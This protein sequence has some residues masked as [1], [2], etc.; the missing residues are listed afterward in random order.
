MILFGIYLFAN[1]F[2]GGKF[3]ID[4]EILLGLK[5]IIGPLMAQGAGAG[6]KGSIIDGNAFQVK[7]GIVFL[8]IL[9]AGTYFTYLQYGYGVFLPYIGFVNGYIWTAVG[10]F[11]G[12]LSAKKSH[13]FPLLESIK[14]DNYIHKSQIDHIFTLDNKGWEEHIKE[15]EPTFKDGWSCVI[16]PCETGSN[17]STVNP[18]GSG[19]SLQPLFSETDPSNPSI[20]IIGT[21]Y[22]KGSIPFEDANFRSDLQSKSQEELGESY[23]L[24]VGYLD[25]TPEMNLIEFTISKK[26]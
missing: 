9:L 4:G 7:S 5:L 21:Y 20:L 26:N 1:I 24:K 18:N 8:I 11:T 22:P 15:L 3:I 25:F 10:F 16:N 23:E 13:V 19:C 14:K 17:F 2:F 6:F 12:Y